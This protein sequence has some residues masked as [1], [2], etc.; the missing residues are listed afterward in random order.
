MQNTEN[1]I[2]TAEQRTRIDY[3]LRQMLCA[4]QIEPYYVNTELLKEKIKDPG[5]LEQF[6]L[7]IRELF[8]EK[9]GKELVTTLQEIAAIVPVISQAIT[10]FLDKLV[11]VPRELQVLQYETNKFNIS[12]ELEL[13]LQSVPL[14]KLLKLSHE[15][16]VSRVENE[17]RLNWKLV[18]ICINKLETAEQCAQLA[19]VIFNAIVIVQTTPDNN[20]NMTWLNHYSVARHF[21]SELRCRKPELHDKIGTGLFNKSY[22][23]LKDVVY[24]LRLSEQPYFTI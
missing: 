15:Q 5:E 22:F 24:E 2:F 21:C 4:L 18:Q 12:I 6:L 19:M 16:Y 10:Q 8:K 1:K 3:I 14:E 23:N 17:F 20:N 7:V 11:Q 13:F 9:K